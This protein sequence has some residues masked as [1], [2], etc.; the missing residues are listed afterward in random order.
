M[1]YAYE[2]DVP[3]DA[4]R[5]AQ[6]IENLGSEPLAG[7]LVH[8]CVTRPEGGLRYIDVWDSQQQCADAFEHRIHPAVDAAFGSARPDV[9]PE[10]RVLKLVH[11]SGAIAVGL[12]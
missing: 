3:I 9:E 10:I 7:L 2:Q 12:S 1:V 4:G 8:L 5:Y 6:I 11:A